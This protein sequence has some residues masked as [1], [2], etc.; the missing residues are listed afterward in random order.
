M[1]YSDVA[2]LDSLFLINVLIYNIEKK[3]K[4]RF[5]FIKMRNLMVQ[6]NNWRLDNSYE[7]QYCTLSLLNDV[8]KIMFFVTE[9]CGKH[10]W[11]QLHWLTLRAG[12]EKEGGWYVSRIPKAPQKISLVLLSA[13]LWRTVKAV[14]ILSPSG[15]MFLLHW[16]SVSGQVDMHS[17][18]VCQGYSLTCLCIS[19]E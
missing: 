12:V 13:S 15:F 16:I 11:W 19:V 2:V 17:G 6:M 10:V 7:Q 18:Q 8:L 4:S 1:N 5:L 14:S 3:N 9:V